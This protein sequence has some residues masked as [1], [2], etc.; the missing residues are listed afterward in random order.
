MG[1]EFVN[2]IKGGVIPSSFIPAVEKGVREAMAAGVLA[3]Y[4]VKDVRVRLYDGS[5]HSVDSSE[6]A[7]KLAGAQAMREALRAG[8][9]GAAGAD[10][11]RHAVGPR[12]V[13]RAT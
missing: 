1:F 6:I 5:Y 3:G 4:P 2:Q 9:S 7:F 8:R 12:G 11:A 10:H 13:R